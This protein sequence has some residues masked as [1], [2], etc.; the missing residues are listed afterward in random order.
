MTQDLEFLNASDYGLA[1]EVPAYIRLYPHKEPDK[2]FG[3]ARICQL[4]QYAGKL[5]FEYGEPQECESGIALVAPTIAHITNYGSTEFEIEIRFGRRDGRLE[6][7]FPDRSV[8]VLSSDARESKASEDLILRSGVTFRGLFRPYLIGPRLGTGGTA[9]VHQVKD[10]T[11]KLFAAKCLSPGRFRLDDLVQRFEREVSHLDEAL[12]RNVV[13][14]VDQAYYGDDLILVMELLTETLA[15]RLSADKPTMDTALTWLEETL[16]GL[17]HLHQLGLVHRDITP[18]NLMFN[19]E[20]RL[21]LSDFGTVKGKADLDFTMDV[22]GVRLGSLLYISNEQRHE[23]HNTQAADDVFSAGQVGYY[24]LTGL[25]PHGNPPPL[26]SF[27]AISPRAADVVERM[28]AYR[29]S[30]RFPDAR[31]ALEALVEARSAAAT[32]SA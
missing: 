4:Y 31:Q 5:A 15:S 24:M 8:L 22:S 23:P 12:H 13:E 1:V 29:R 10:P 9:V 26:T 2:R 16:T 32:S 27:T 30:D 21:K 25:A 11:G 17:A 7:A 20:G 3:P 28:R 19:S 14:Y 18:S 6:L